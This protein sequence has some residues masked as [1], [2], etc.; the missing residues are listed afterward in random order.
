MVCVVSFVCWGLLSR[1]HAIQFF[2]LGIEY[3]HI[4]HLYTKVPGYRL[5]EC[6]ES[7]PEGLWE[8]IHYMTYPDQWHSLSCTVYD[9]KK[10]RYTSYP[11]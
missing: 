9:E 8:G 1:A 3:H 5:R 10:G 7:A 2:T 11:W 6:H 4:H